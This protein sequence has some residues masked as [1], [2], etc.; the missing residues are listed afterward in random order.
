MVNVLVIIFATVVFLTSSVESQS[1]SAPPKVVASYSA[2]NARVAP[3]WIAQDQG[4]FKKYGTDIDAVFIRTGPLQV[5]SLISGDTDI[6]Y[7]GATN[8]VGAAGGGSDLRILASFTNRVIYD[9]V[10]RPG[11]KSPE[12][13]RGK[14]FGVQAIGGT[15]WMGAILGLEHLGLEPVR[16]NISMLNVGDQSVLAQALLAGTIDATVLDGVYSRRLNERGFPILAEFSKINI[17]FSS[18]GIV[19]RQ[20]YLERQPS[21]TLENF[22]KAILEANAFLQRPASKASVLKILMRRLRVSE[23]EAEEG[24][25][26]TLAGL[27]LKPY[28]SLEGMLNIQRL[29]KLRNPKLE[30]VKVVELIDDRILRKLDESGFIER[31][32]SSYGVK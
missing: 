8:A 17:P 29:M 20:G 5:A 18:T 11:I 7:M 1:A 2:M 3:L 4:Y 12:D 24:Y 32:Y 30:K 10:V 21:A 27:D 28:P 16:D 6:G 26:D 22:L 31:L 23:R 15:V 19:V 13:L 25:R 14:R 9:L